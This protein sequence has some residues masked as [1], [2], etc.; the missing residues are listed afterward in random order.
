MTNCGIERKIVE[1]KW[2]SVHSTQSTLEYRSII[3]ALKRKKSGEKRSRFYIKLVIAECN[4]MA[5][6]SERWAADNRSMLSLAVDKW[7]KP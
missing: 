3:I 4:L 1:R 7:D 5:G 2:V 6:K